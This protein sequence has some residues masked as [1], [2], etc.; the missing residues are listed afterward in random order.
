MMQD[1]Q[2]QALAYFAAFVALGLTTASIGPT[3][4]GLAANTRVGLGAI[5][6]VFTARALGYTAGSVW[7]GK[8][9][10]RLPGHKV[11]AGV[12]LLMTATMALT[13]LAPAL[14][15]LLIIS[16]PLGLAEGAVDVCGNTLMVWS[17]PGGAGHFL[18]ALHF[19]YGA[20]A[21][22][23]PLIVA[24]SYALRG[25]AN[26]SYWFIAALI[27]PLGLWL[28]RVP[29][30]TPQTDKTDAANGR[31]NRS[32]VVLIT[33]FFFLYV[34][35]EVS[36]GGWIFTYAVTL[37]LG[38]ATDAA[39]LTAV[40]WGALTL[41]RLLAIPVARRFRPRAILFTDLAGALGCLALLLWR[42]ASVPTLW[43]AT[44]GLG[45][46]IASIFPT[47]FAFAERRISITGRV[48]G[49]F[50]LGA[51]VGTKVLALLTGQLIAA[52]GPLALLVV[53][54][55]ALCLAAAMFV[56]ALRLAP[57]EAT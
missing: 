40:F 38:T 22:L 23:A 24:R 21:L 47:M 32:L 3:L 2:K 53:A 33:V 54:L 9:L 52:H 56:A 1:S 16:L 51:S 12:L 10:D 13:P 14:W 35:V 27:A 26:W 57:A 34:G 39:Y 30:P 17:R 44:G 18:N 20:G 41:G 46:F 31:T 55:L 36:F 8:L 43:L 6:L 25:D 4:M 48:T 49:W 11:L 50:V 37:G 42:P 29:A 7:S 5:S 45:L 28:L 15:L 19:F